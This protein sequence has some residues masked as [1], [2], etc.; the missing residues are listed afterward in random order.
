[1]LGVFELLK[2]SFEIYKSRFW[3]LTGISAVPSL[4]MFFFALASLAFLAEMQKF[5]GLPFILIIG[6]LWL[7]VALS[8][9]FWSQISLLY[10]IKDRNEKIGIKEA[11]RRGWGKMNSFAWVL[12]LTGFITMGGSMLFMIPGIIFSIWFVFASYILVNENIGGMNALM[13]SKAYVQGHWWSVFWRFLAL[14][15]I[16]IGPFIALAIILGAI[17]AGITIVAGKTGASIF[18]D[19]IN[20]LITTF[21]TPFLIIYSFL[22]YENLKEIK[23]I[24]TFEPKGKGWLIAI[25]ILGGLII[26][27]F[28]IQ[29]FMLSKTVSTL[30]EMVTVNIS[31]G[32]KAAQNAKMQSYMDQLRTT[33]A[34]W[35]IS[36]TPGTYIG[37]NTNGD[38]LVLEDKIK[39]ISG[40]NYYNAIVSKNSYCVKA[41]L[42]QTKEATSYSQGGDYWCIDSANGYSGAINGNEYCTAEK[43]YCP[44]YSSSYPTY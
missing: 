14:G 11:F 43:P 40:N 6:L 1:M 22:L 21:L 23:G 10:A 15:L 39:K 38:G 28:I 29:I 36:Q 26:P 37:F 25:A 8:V 32:A 9:Q 33:A 24:F 16:F 2:K 41:K 7:L 19:S 12:I 20:F 4:L 18:S 42:V 44:K 3:A 35:Q 30:S 13:K 5:L 17:T 31:S 34:F 27:I